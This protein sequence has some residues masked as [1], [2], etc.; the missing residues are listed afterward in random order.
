MV[1][2]ST[3]GTKIFGTNIFGPV[4]HLEN[5]GAETAQ[6]LFL[7][8]IACVAFRDFLLHNSRHDVVPSGQE[9]P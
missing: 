6:D 9:I 4:L 7:T 8:G 5:S 2:M 3:H 1:A